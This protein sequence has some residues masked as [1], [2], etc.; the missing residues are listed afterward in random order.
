MIFLR[1]P[2]KIFV[3]VTFSIVIVS[4]VMMA[5]ALAADGAPSYLSAYVAVLTGLLGF[6]GSWV[7]AQIG[8]ANFKRQRT[9]DKQ[10]E[11]YERAFGAI[12]SM[13]EKIQIACTSEANKEPPEKLNEQW[14]DVQLAHRAVDRVSLEAPLYGTY[15]AVAQMKKIARTVQEVADKTEAFDPTKFPKSTGGQEGEEELP[16]SQELMDEI[17]WLGEH[18]EKS[19]PALIGEGR[20]HLGINRRPF[21][22]RRFR[23]PLDKSDYEL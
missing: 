21:W 8:L 6:I 18:L 2:L 19:S 15:R 4:I 16:S 20:K 10:L 12:H 13:A 14:R 9:F 1:E 5:P 23:K 3:G 17:E 22:N 11:W 7:G